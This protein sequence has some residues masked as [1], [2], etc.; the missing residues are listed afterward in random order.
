[1]DAARS[2]CREGNRADAPA[3]RWRKTQGDRAREARSLRD[4]RRVAALAE[5]GGRRSRPT[6][7]GGHFAYLLRR[8][9]FSGRSTP[10]SRFFEDFARF[11]IGQINRGTLMPA[12]LRS[13]THPSFAIVYIRFV[14][15]VAN[16][17]VK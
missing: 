12:S 4:G 14:R 1:G 6:P 9:G 10:L 17:V 5:F 15:P 13:F 7:E 2:G 11:L 3:A 8:A 16:V